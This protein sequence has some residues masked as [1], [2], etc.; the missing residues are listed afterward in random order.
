MNAH[1]ATADKAR[2]G[3]SPWLVILSFIVLAAL[4]TGWFASAPRPAFSNRR[5]TALD[6]PG[7]A[8]Q[9][10]AVFNAGDCASCHA[11]PGQPDRLRLGG[12]LPLPSPMGVFH[13]PNISSDPV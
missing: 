3:M 12:G 13:V 10:R 2:Y 8:E 7:D 9:G 6:G 5:D 1:Q 4:A 11:S